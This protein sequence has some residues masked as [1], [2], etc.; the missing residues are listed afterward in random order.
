MAA[1]SSPRWHSAEIS[2]F[3]APIIKHIYDDCKKLMD[4][5]KERE[6]SAD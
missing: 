3:D 4:E 6:R 1:T 2:T 5:M